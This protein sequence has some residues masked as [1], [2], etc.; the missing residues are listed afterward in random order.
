MRRREFITLLCG[1]AVTWPLAAHTQQARKLYRVALVFNASPVAE[2]I[3]PD[4][5]HPATRSFVHT[6]RSL[7]YVEGKNLVLEHRS[8]EGKNERLPE[9]MRELVSIKAD[10]IVTVSNPMTRAAMDVTR[11]VPIVMAISNN[12]VEYGLVQSLSRP[13]GN[14]TGLTGS[15][16]PD[17]PGKQLQLLKE[18]L[19]RISQVAYLRSKEGVQEGLQAG[20]TAARKLGIKLLF[21]EHTPTDYTGAF[22]LIARERRDALVVNASTASWANRRSIIEFAAERRIPAMYA[23]REYVEDG[24]LMSY[25]TSTR[26][27]LRR[28]ARYVDKILKGAAPADLPVEQP[29]KFDLVVNLKT[30]KALGLTIPPTFLAQVSEVIE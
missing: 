9:I 27:L 8:A 16:G 18:L 22:A 5:I 17:F 14:V 1:A 13:G 4:P 25:G 2:M 19:P 15:V 30:A 7:G 29:I 24:A 6:L 3:G 10:V 11:T 23:A 12:P 26:D 28:A 20:E 21:A